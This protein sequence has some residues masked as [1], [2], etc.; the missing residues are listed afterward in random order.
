MSIL[1]KYSAHRVTAKGHSLDIK[2]VKSLSPS[3][4]GRS[5]RQLTSLNS[6]KGVIWIYLKYLYAWNLSNPE[7]QGGAGYKEAQDPRA[8][9]Q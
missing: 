9:Q 7:H 4:V 6:T 8:N 5:H 2:E 3:L 1:G